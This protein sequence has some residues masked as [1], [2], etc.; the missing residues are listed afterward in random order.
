MT[1]DNGDRLT[2]ADRRSMRILARST[3]ATG[4]ANARIAERLERAA[5]SGDRSDYQRAEESFDSLPA[6]ERRRIGTHAER[7]AETERQLLEARRQQPMPAKPAPAADDTLDWK[8]LILDHSPSTDPTD[9]G[10]VPSVPRPSTP[11]PA[12]VRRPG[13][14]PAP[15]PQGRP[16]SPRPATGASTPPPRPKGPAQGR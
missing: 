5:G 16:A 12:S 10:T 8:P 13:G 6:K 7:Q 4:P 2:D 9:A 3:K 14:S 1:G 15:G 11:R